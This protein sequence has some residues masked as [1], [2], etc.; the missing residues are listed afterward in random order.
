V[1][2]HTLRKDIKEFN[3]FHPHLLSHV[4]EFWY[5]E[6]AHNVV[7]H[8][9]SFVNIGAV[10]GLKCYISYRESG[11]YFQIRADSSKVCVLRPGAQLLLQ[12][13]SLAFLPFI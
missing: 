3:I 11:K 6:Y 5:K 2:N 8:L 4:T 12:A 1:K 10:L 13:C 7:E 9:K